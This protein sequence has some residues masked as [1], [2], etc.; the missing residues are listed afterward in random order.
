MEEIK[1]ALNT[2]YEECHKHDNCDNCKI[3]ELIGSKVCDSLSI[4]EDWKVTD[5]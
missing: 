3:W 2:L 1:Q 5:E 4:P